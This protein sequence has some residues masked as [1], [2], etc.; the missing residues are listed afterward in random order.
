MDGTGLIHLV[1]ARHPLLKG[2][3]VPISVEL[4]GSFDVLVITGPN[5]GGKTVALKTVGLLSLMAQCGLQIPAAEGSSL[6]IFESIFADIGDEQSIEQSLSTF[7]SH[8]THIVDILGKADRGSLVLLDELGAGTDPQEGSALARAILSFLLERHVPTIAT[9]HYSELKSFAHTTPGVENAS[10]EF[11][12]ETLSPTYRLSI[13]LPGRSNALAIANRLG[14]RPEI[15]DSARE[16]LGETGVEMEGLL[17]RLQADRDAAQAGSRGGGATAGPD[18]LPEGQAQRGAGSRSR[19]EG[20]AV[21]EQARAQSEQELAAL[22]SKVQHVLRELERSRTQR[23]AV[24]PI[25]SVAKEAEA[26]KPL[27]APGRRRQR[28]ERTP[29]QDVRIGQPV[30]VSSLQQ[31]GTVSSLPDDRGGV[32]VQIGPMRTR[33]NVRELSRTDGERSEKARE[34]EITYRLDMDRTLEV[35]MQLDLRGK[36]AEE[37]MDELDRYL[38]DVYMAGL[39]TVR[40]VHGKGTGVVRHAVREQLAASPLVRHFEQA[41]ANEGGEGAT[42]AFMAV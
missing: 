21:L 9:T 20:A 1:D 24:A 33:V 14:M 30:Y 2:N 10:V 40:I 4:G 6:G 11:D 19:S 42:L 37:A 3:V 17:S 18:A 12:L 7:S 8:V 26:L 38:N 28:P 22:R 27:R 36:R 41:P 32:E 34:P 16:L 29:V 13:G 39:K 23:E 5:T 15:L 31:V 35:S 25:A